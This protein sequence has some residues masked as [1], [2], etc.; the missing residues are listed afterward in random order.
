[1]LI[2]LVDKKSF[3]NYFSVNF[4]FNKF[5]TNLGGMSYNVPAVYDVW[6]GIKGFCVAKTARPNVPE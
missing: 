4:L 6:A 5:P 2:I 1:M 3:V